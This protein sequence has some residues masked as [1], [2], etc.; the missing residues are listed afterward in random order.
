MNNILIKKINELAIIP[1]RNKLSDA[2][3]DLFSI[4]NVTIKSNQAVATK[5][6]TGI[7]IEIPNGYFG[8]I[9]DRSSIGSK[10]IK[11]MGGIIDSGYRGELIVCLVN[12]GI[13]EYNINIGDKIA[14]LLIIPYNTSKIIEVNELS[15]TERGDKGFGS[16][17]Q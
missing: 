14:Q 4:D 7:A 9:S 3:L 13:N 16:S 2:G 15:E 6:K 11:V 8:L 17:G 5:I 1:H 12:L 10:L